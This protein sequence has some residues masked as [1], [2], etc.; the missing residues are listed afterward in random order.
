M[1]K[2]PAWILHLFPVLPFALGHRYLGVAFLLLV[3]LA[4]IKV[5]KLRLAQSEQIRR[6]GKADETIE[7]TRMFWERLTFLPPK[8]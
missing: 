4:Y 3:G 1:K 2:I 5:N 8:V 6:H 7:T